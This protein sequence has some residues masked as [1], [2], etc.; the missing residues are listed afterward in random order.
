MIFVCVLCH[1]II[2]CVCIGLLSCLYY[3]MEDVLNI[4]LWSVATYASITANTLFK[5][6]GQA[7]G[8]PVWSM[9]RAAF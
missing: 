7:M 1:C 6:S 4:S 9:N 2:L 3:G 8:Y 5:L